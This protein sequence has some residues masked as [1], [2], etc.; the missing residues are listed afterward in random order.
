MS[1]ECILQQ[2][3]HEPGE[4]ADD[5]LEDEW[6]KLV[7]Q[8]YGH[9]EQSANAA[10][11]KSKSSTLASSSSA[12][13]PEGSLPVFKGVNDRVFQRNPDGSTKALGALAVVLLVLFLLVF[14]VFLAMIIFW[15]T[16]R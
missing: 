12:C 9:G 15:G 2:D 6:S 1:D 14:V 3:Q 11:T 10:Q 16:L 5:E 13:P 7:E 8:R 4:L